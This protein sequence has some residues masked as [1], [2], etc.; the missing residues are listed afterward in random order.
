VVSNPSRHGIALH[1]DADVRV[2]VYDAAGRT[3]VS[4][5]ATRGLSFLPLPTGAYFVKAGSGTARAVV[6]D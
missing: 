2:S 3:V 5:A 1:S 4:Q 6:T